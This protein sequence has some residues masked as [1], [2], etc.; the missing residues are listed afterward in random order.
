MGYYPGPYNTSMTGTN[1]YGQPFIFILPFIEQQNMYNG[2]LALGGGG[3]SWTYA[4][5]M[6]TGIKTY[7]CPS[8]PTISIQANPLNCSYADNA[9]LFGNSAVSGG[10]GGTA[11]FN[12]AAGS[13]GGARFPATIT[14]GTSNTIMWTEKLGQCGS[15]GN[16]NMWPCTVMTQP[17]FSAVGAVTSPPNAYFQIGANKNTCS[18]YANASTG[19]SGVI[20]AGLGDASV[21]M[22][23]QGMST[24]TYGLAL[25]PNDGFPM[26]SDW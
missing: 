24:T 7:V 16:S 25:I 5:N 13:A 9:L 8:D 6:Q 10:T 23:A 4:N 2:M 14:D 3:N 19:H 17:I 11:T 20:L 1:L 15:T 12:L 18:S 26:P 21:K 22:I